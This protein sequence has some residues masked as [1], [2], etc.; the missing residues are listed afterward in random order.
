TTYSFTDIEKDFEILE[1]ID[2]TK[3]DDVSDLS[4]I[5]SKPIDNADKLPVSAD[6]MNGFIDSST[7][8]IVE[9]VQ[10]QVE[11]E[12]NSSN[13]DISEEAMNKSLQSRMENSNFLNA[14]S[15]PKNVVPIT[16]T[17]I[18]YEDLTSEINN[19]EK[20]KIEDD[21]DLIEA[22]HQNVTPAE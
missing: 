13:V 21:I 5:P 12:K 10:K 18:I 6:K 16:N 8:E 20:S 17:E 1:T 14:F 19:F 15:N 11:A 3:D 7:M 9:S 2:I 22:E 4:K